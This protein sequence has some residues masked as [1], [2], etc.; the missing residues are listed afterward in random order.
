M[1]I[2]V[3]KVQSGATLIEVLITVVVMSVGLLGIAAL[4]IMAVRNSQ[5]SLQQSLATMYT[6]AILDSMRANRAAALRGAYNVTNLCTA[7]TG[8]G[9]P[10]GDRAFWLNAAKAQLGGSTCGDIAC[11]T[12]GACTSTLRWSDAREKT[13][14]VSVSTRAQI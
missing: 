13:S 11:N 5:Q 9:L 2:G 3:P 1:S 4:Q 6:Y 8:T 12:S 7:P 14:Q 10:D